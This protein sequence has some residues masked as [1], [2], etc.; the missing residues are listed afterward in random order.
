MTLYFVNVS[1][2]VTIRVK[3]GDVNDNK[4]KF[5]NTIYYAN[6]KED[7]FISSIVTTVEAKDE[8]GKTI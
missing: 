5:E 1:D 2:I 7:A 4:P 3:I 6:V 8:D